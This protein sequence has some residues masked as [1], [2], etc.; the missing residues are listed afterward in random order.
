[1]LI[2]PNLVFCMLLSTAVEQKKGESEMLHCP[3]SA[4]T[5]WADCEPNTLFARG[6]ATLPARMNPYARGHI[7]SPLGG[8]IFADR[9]TSPPDDIEK[10]FNILFCHISSLMPLSL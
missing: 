9:T 1:M 4:W 6:K 5:E 2:H 3:S 7:P 10:D 8:V